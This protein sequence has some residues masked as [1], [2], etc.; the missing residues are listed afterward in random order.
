MIVN[1]N[2][3]VKG[4][5]KPKQSMLARL[6]AYCA[7]LYPAESNHLMD[8]ASL[9]QGDVLFLV[10]YVNLNALVNAYVLVL[11][12]TIATAKR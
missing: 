5:L 2:P 1:G 11:L 9:M 6:D 3:E 8:V 7:A 10:A 4:R 12:L